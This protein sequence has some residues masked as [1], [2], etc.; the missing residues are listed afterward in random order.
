MTDLPIIHRVPGAP[1]T[2]AADLSDV[3]AYQ[4]LISEIQNVLTERS[5][6]A[7][8]EYI[9]AKYEVGELL[10]LSPLYTRTQSGA[11]LIVDRVAADIGVTWGEVYRCVRFYSRCQALGGL[12]AFRASLP[13]GKEITW[14]YIKRYLPAHEED[15]MLPPKK[16]P[17]KVP[18]Q[19]SASR[20]AEGRLGLEWREE[21]QQKLTDL[22]QV[23][24]S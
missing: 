21:D 18:N 7:H 2:I 9:K 11:K 8:S 16:R 22:L 4:L 23:R 3:E 20:Y 14:T 15:E 19:P 5:A 24:G 17:K 12:E 13:A 6:R 1:G 10:S